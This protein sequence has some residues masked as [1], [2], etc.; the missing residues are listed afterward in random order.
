MRG[1]EK[2]LT[3][4]HPARYEDLKSRVLSNVAE[5]VATRE[6]HFR[7]LVAASV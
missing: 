6:F 5:S 3:V 2:M 4:I 1:Y 7:V